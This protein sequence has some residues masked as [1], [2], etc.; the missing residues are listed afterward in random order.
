MAD[1]FLEMNEEDRLP[2]YV[3]E[4]SLPEDLPDLWKLFVDGVSRKGQCGA[5]MLLI[6]PEGVEISYALRFS[7]DATN[8]KA[9]YEAL[10]AGLKIAHQ[11]EVKNIS[12]FSDSQAVVNQVQGE[13]QTKNERMQKYLTKITELIKLF[14]HFQITQIPREKNAKVDELNKLVTS[15]PIQMKHTVIVEELTH[16]VIDNQDE[17]ITEVGEPNDCWMTPIKKFLQD[18]T[19]PTNPIEAKRIKRQALRYIIQENKLYRRSYLQ[20]LL[21]CIRPR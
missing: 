10:H 5:S 20:P 2:E 16:P 6:F 4:T 13:Y 19:L 1:F 9:E 21:R 12:I 15:T 8:N 11:I 18:G 17:L 3:P 7:F 14:Q